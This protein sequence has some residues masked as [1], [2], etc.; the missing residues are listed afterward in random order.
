MDAL[1]FAG[2]W[3]VELFKVVLRKALGLGGA[4]LV[5]GGSASTKVVRC[6]SL[7]VMAHFSL[8][9]RIVLSTTQVWVGFYSS[10]TR[11]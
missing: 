2:L 3:G 9:A 7:L 10:A 8:T 11:Y 1:G 4:G 6:A 5:G